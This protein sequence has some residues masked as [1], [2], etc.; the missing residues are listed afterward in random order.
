MKKT[1]AWRFGIYCVI[2]YGSCFQ[3]GQQFQPERKEEIIQHE[4][5]ESAD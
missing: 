4:A 2:S 5:G 1:A 3:K